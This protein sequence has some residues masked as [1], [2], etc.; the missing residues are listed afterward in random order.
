[1]MNRES[2]VYLGRPAPEHVADTLALACGR[3][4][5]GAEY[6]RNTVA[7]PEE[8]GIHDRG[9]WKLQ[10]LVAERIISPPTSPPFP[11]GRPL[12]N[13]KT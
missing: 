3:W 7:H 1:V 2:R 4:G 6:L 11:C 10:E 5:S 13:P 9:L 8:H 12:R